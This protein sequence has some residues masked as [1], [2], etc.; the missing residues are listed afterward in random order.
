MNKIA[1]YALCMCSLLTLSCSP[2][3]IANTAPD[4]PKTEVPDSDEPEEPEE[5]EEQVVLYER[6]FTKEIDLT[7]YQMINADGIEIE[8]P[9]YTGN[10][11]QSNTGGT[12]SLSS[13]IY[14]PENQHDHWLITEGFYIDKPKVIVAWSMVAE[15]R[16]ESYEVYIS[17]SPDKESFTNKIFAGVL[18]RW[19]PE[20]EKNNIGKAEKLL[21]GYK[22]KTIYLA[23]RH[24]T[25]DKKGF[26]LTLK[27]LK[28]SSFPYNNEDLTTEKVWLTY[29]DFLP[30]GK[31]TDTGTVYPPGVKLNVSMEVKN[32]GTGIRDG[33]LKLTCKYGDNEITETVEGVYL[34]Q[35]DTLIY[36]FKKP[37]STVAA[38]SG[39]TPHIT[40]TVHPL[41]G[42]I[43]V[44]NNSQ[45]VIL[46]LLNG[47]P[48]YRMLFEKL[49]KL[50]CV[51]CG[52]TFYSFDQLNEAYPERTI[53]VCTMY[54][55]GLNLPP[56]FGGNYRSMI[57]NIS[58][59]PGTP[60][61]CFDRTGEA[62][63]DLE[64][65]KSIMKN[66]IFASRMF[67][68]FAIG[69][70]HDFSEDGTTMY[71]H[72]SATCLLDQTDAD[73]N[74]TA[75]VL[76]DNIIEYPNQS[77]VSNAVHNHIIRDILGDDWKLGMANVIP[78]EAKSGETYTHTFEY[79]VPSTYGK[80]T[81]DRKQ[82]YAVGAIINSASG[83]IINC[84]KSN[85]SNN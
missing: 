75:L 25:P 80:H 32:L 58:Q 36:T 6:D 45:D 1:L 33:E 84:N 81:T 9:F 39:N 70:T 82:L 38:P 8:S 2:D 44:Q 5:P 30:A 34:P 7:D 55:D 43:Q 41:P 11:Y 73:L 63:P 18:P 35:G 29:P 61:G 10:W 68:P 42:E 52:Q 40:A 65:L 53:G 67:P 56:A 49:S 17:T 57:A 24:N 72:V 15:Y 20:L 3:E 83:E 37:L 13:Y 19:T 79:S 46:T 85:K 50:N 60:A 51:P 14:D 77:G 4:G 74:L 71:I 62:F 12:I 28:I 47:D 66:G 59:T 16:D 23:F 76:E 78:A 69:V 54:D 31:N 21:E 48:K 27:K 26:L 22:G 64:K